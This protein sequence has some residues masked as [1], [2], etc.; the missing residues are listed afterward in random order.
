MNNAFVDGADGKPRVVRH[1]HVNLGLAV[2]VDKADG[3]RTLLV[4]VHPRRRH[5]RLRRL[6]RR[7]RGPHPQGPHQQARPP[8]TSQGA[9][10]TLTNPGTIGTVQ[11]RAAAHARPGRDRRRRRAST[12]RPSSRAPTERT[13]GR[14]RRH[15]RSSRSRRTYDHRIIQGAESG[16]F[17]KR[18][19]E[20]LLG[21]RRLLRRRL[22]QP[23]RAVRGGAV[24]PRRQP[25]RPR[26][27]RCSRSR[28]RS[29]TLIR[30][31]RVRGHLIAD[32]DPLRVEGAAHARRARPGHLRAHDLGP[33]PRVPHRRPRPARTRMTLGDILHVLRDAYCRTIGIEYMHIQDTDRAALDPASRS[34]ACR[35][36]LSTRRAAPHP[37]PAQRGRGVREVPRHEVRRP[38]SAS[39]SRA[40]S[41]RS[42]SSTRS[43][44]T[45]A[46]DGLDGAV[47]G[48]AHRGRL[49]VLANIVGKSYDQIFKEFEGYVD[50]NSMQGSG[51]VKYHLGAD[52]QVRQPVRRRHHASSWPP[53]RSHLE[54]VDPVVDG[55]GA[56]RAGPASTSPASFPV[57]PLLI[58]GDAAFA[59][60]GV[61]AETLQPVR[62]SRATASA[63]RSTSSSTT[64]SGSPPRPSA[65]RSSEYCTDVAKMVQAPIFHVNGD[66]PEACVRVARLAFDVPPDV[67]QGRRHRHGLL[68][69][70]RS[71]RGRRPELH[72]AADVQAR[73]TSGARSASSTPRRWCK[74]GDITARRGRGARSTTSSAGCRSRS[75]RPAG[76]RRPSRRQGAR[77][78]EPIGVLPHVDDRRRPRRRSTRI[79]DALI[80]RP[81]EGFTVHPKLAKQF[82]TRATRCTH[83]GRGRLGARRGAGVRL[84]AARGHRRAPR[85]RRTPG[86]A[87][88]AS[89]TRCSST[90]RPAPSA[91]R[92]ATSPPTRR[93]F[94]VYDSLL[95]EYA[96]ARLRV[97]LLGGQQ[98]RARRS[99]R[100]SS[101]TSSTARRS[102]S[103]STSW[104]PRTSGARRRA[105][106]CCCRTATRAR[107]PSTRSA[108]IERFLTLCAED[109]IQ[110]VQRHDRRR[111]TSTCCAGR[112]AA[113]CAS[114]S[115]LHARSRCCARSRRARRSSALDRRL[116]PGG[117]RRPGVI[118]R[119]RRRAAR[120]VLLRSG[121]VAYDAHG[122]A[123]RASVRPSPSSGSSSST[124]CPRSSSL[125]RARA[126]TRTPSEVVWL[127]EEPENM[128][129]VELRARPAATA[130]S[131]TTTRCATSAASSRAARRPAATP[132]T[133]RSSS[134]SSTRPSADV[135][136][137]RVGRKS[138]RAISVPKRRW[139]GWSVGRA[140][141]AWRG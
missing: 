92:C 129:A 103:T 49:N 102:S 51:D 126:A 99:G 83:D 25:G 133:S 78:P 90:T 33:R 135:H 116:V 39:A 105:S 61:V 82:E 98:G 141:W 13:L 9:T 128:G 130:C 87:R 96:A 63:A 134:R 44:T 124:R 117:A 14:A 65:A 74:R 54:T 71:Q 4:P 72:A 86:A 7:L 30:V 80:A 6:L 21:E 58:H 28:C 131:A 48:M 45:A 93:K 132:S 43:S 29:H 64:R 22:P 109:N 67:P 16:L 24:A 94:W 12:T 36:Q 66:D 19:H 10:V 26:S 59:G 69:A 119:R 60:Q 88:S 121:K 52:R 110:V 41:R 56:G 20:L 85:R 97:R 137:P 40:P 108:R 15:R 125:E 37:R 23:R 57:L 140:G 112:C 107:A 17:L 55:H 123:R 31:H 70:P 27:R 42:R 122:A 139:V 47:L 1:E 101:A 84:A 111:S 38:R 8:T 11:S 95:S 106:C 136:R 91:R 3:T 113:T 81:P 46:D 2:D 50:P 127:Q 79:F 73:S 76:A 5:A 32:L 53:T 138:V 34:R 104:P 18:V 89:A 120:V 62:P 114:R 100:R 68:P 75:T 118:D 115:C 77:P 35:R